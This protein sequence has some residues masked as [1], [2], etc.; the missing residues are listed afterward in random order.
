MPKHLRTS[1]QKRKSELEENVGTREI[2]AVNI[3]GSLIM[4]FDNEQTENQK[5]RMAKSAHKR[6][7]SNDITLPPV[8]SISV[9]RPTA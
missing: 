1:F 9:R 5:M 8:K 4:D 2:S 6:F 3:C 7:K